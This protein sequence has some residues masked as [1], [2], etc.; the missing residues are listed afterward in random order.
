[1]AMGAR[2]TDLS[3][4]LGRQTGWVVH[5]F[6]EVDSTNDEACRLRDAG[7]GPRTA[8]LADAQRAGRGRGGRAFA[9]PPGGL[10]LSLL[11]QARP[12]D[13]PH[14]AVALAALAARAAVAAEG[15]AAG[16]KWPNDLWVGGRKLGGILLEA[17]GA[18]RPVV[19]GVGLNLAAVPPGLEP[20][21]AFTALEA[22]VGRPVD[23]TRLVASLLAAVDHWSA[24]LRAPGGAEALAAAW[25]AALL[26]VGESVSLRVGGSE[27]HGRLLDAGLER[28]LLLDPGAGD[29]VWLPAARIAELRPWPRR[30]E[31]RERGPN[32]PPPGGGAGAAGA[33]P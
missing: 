6:A 28:G 15:A 33:T 1:M 25:R 2:H 24:R 22:E 17:A 13:L 14:A 8:V 27:V 30:M 11:W 4:P 23:R 3:G 26:L 9:S 12:A 20:R 29:P 21:A 19:I 31:A 32:G 10:Y 5:H 16:L 18:E 7:A